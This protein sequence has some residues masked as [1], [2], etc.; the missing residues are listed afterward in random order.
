MKLYKRTN[1]YRASNVCFDPARIEAS[2][3]DWWIFVKKIRG[4]VVF[5]EYR[6]SNSTAKHQY[7][8][9][10]L[11]DQLG[12]KIDLV[13][14][15]KESLSN[16]KFDGITIKKLKAESEAQVAARELVRKKRAKARRIGK[17]LE[18]LGL[19]HVDG[20]RVDPWI[21]GRKLADISLN[22][23]YS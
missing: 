5:N 18:T 6:Y 21:E 23:F 17:R 20:T 15:V 16:I 11:M 14:S 9:R 22:D 1:V 3:Y 4:L 2:S 13:V 10:D 19:Y 12:I 8:V 7:K